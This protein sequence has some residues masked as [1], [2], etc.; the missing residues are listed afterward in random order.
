MEIIFVEKFR[1]LKFRWSLSYNFLLLDSKFLPWRINY[2]DTLITKVY[3][4]F[5]SIGK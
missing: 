3:V 5:I 2:T 4:N 1:E